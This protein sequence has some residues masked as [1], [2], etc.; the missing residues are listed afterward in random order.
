MYFALLA[1]GTIIVVASC[2]ETSETYS[3]FTKDGEIIYVGTPDTVIVAPG[4]E[5]LK[6]SIVIN[7][8]PK[9][10]GG[11]LQTKDKSFNHEFDVERQSN[12]NDTISFIVNLDEGEYNFDVL[13][14][15][16]SG[17]T[18]I[19]REV[20]TVVY[21]TKYQNALLS[22]S[23][24]AIKAFETHAVLTW[25]DVPNGS[26]STSISYEDA[27]GAMQTIEVSNDISETT[28]SSYKLGGSIIVKSIYAP[29]SNAIDVF[30][31]I[32]ET[33]FPEQ[34]QI[35]HTNITALRMPFD[36]SDGCYGSSYERLTDGATGEFWHSCDSVEDQY[37]FVM[38]FDIGV[39]A[40]LSGFRLDKRSECCG[41][42]SPASYQIWA[43]NE[44]VGA[45]TMD[46]DAD[47]DENNV[48]IAH[49]EADAISKG[50]VKLVE[51][52]DN[53]QETFEVLI[54]ENSTN[55]RYVRLVAISSING[56]ITANFDELTFM[57]TAV[58]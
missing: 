43:T 2:E 20:T 31:S 29:R 34:F 24:S 16:D 38:S 57:A 45:E 12:G 25:G 50:W 52:T 14:K 19:P 58:D 13:L 41:G 15:D 32:S 40:N 42:R 51:V 28:L 56:E 46:I 36:A 8:D 44:I 17:N 21:G 3:E 11:V 7:A 35:N 54:P 9:I 5:K 1:I 6:F 30:S 53:T 49:W 33:V 23:I 10:S 37:P 47:G 39:A 55:Y 26:I 27:N 48:S 18:S 4:F 22:R